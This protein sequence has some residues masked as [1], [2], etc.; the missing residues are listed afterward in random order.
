MPNEK[1]EWSYGWNEDADTEKN[2]CLLIGDSIVWGSR[3]D[4]RK[5]LPEKLTLSTF[6]TSKGVDSPYLVEEIA[7]FCRQSGSRFDA[8]YFNNGLHPHGQAPEEYGKNYRHV[9]SRLRALLPNAKWLLGLSTPISWEIGGDPASHSAPIEAKRR[10][11]L[12]EADRLVRVYNE[13]VRAIAREEDL[14]CFDAYTLM[15]CHADQKTDPY[16]Y[17]PQGRRIF[18]SAVAEQLLRLCRSAEK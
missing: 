2:R 6:A 8:V 5:A 13:Q 4:V 11:E 9:L 10:E 15:A 16:H 18:G 17:D 1:I 3:T 7:L 12:E 14:P